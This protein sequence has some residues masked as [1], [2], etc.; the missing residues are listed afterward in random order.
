MPTT[1]LYT[2]AT[3]FRRVLAT[4]TTASGFVT[5]TDLAAAPTLTDTGFESAAGYVS[6]GVGALSG[7]SPNTALFKFFGTN[8]ND[9]TGSCRVYGVR[10]LLDADGGESWTHVLL[11]QFEFIL[12]ST[13]T[14]VSGGVVGADE[15][16]ADT[17][18]RTYGNENVS[19]QLLSP[20]GNLPAHALVDVKGHPLLLVEPIVGTA[21][22]V[23]ALVAGV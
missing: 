21:A 18:S 12:S 6:F 1:A 20:A 15:Y 19:D 23:N 2:D 16:Y 11:A 5:R 22:S 10:R 13:L 3:V 9:E 7:Y 17:V 14:G 4:S 8:A